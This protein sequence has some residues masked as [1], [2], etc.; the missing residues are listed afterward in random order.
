MTEPLRELLP[1]RHAIA[2]VRERKREATQALLGD[3]IRLGDDQWQ[4]PSRL[5]GW[6]RAH[7]ATHVARNAEALCRAVD[8][9]LNGRPRMLYASR[10]QADEDIEV[11][12]RRTGLDLQIDLDTSAGRL[13]AAFDDL[14]AS[15]I[16]TPTVLTERLRVPAQWWIVARLSEVVLHHIDL[17]CGLEVDQIDPQLA[18]W[19]LAWELIR[20]VGDQ[21]IPPVDVVASSGIKGRVGPL[22]RRSLGTITGR[23]ADLVGWLSG[24]GDG[25]GLSGTAVDDVPVLLPPH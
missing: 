12:S 10:S 15:E 4:E 17:A 24:R 7:V 13:N 3:T 11:G 20:G 8:A 5:A 25:A 19:L 18:R 2:R 16:M 9:L 6:T 21:Q 1:D 22:D 23:D 14:E